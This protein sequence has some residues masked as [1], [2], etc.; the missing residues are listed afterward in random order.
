MSTVWSI[1][2]MREERNQA[3]RLAHRWV[4]LTTI[5]R[6]I[7]PHYIMGDDGLT[8]YLNPA[9]VGVVMVARKLC[10]NWL[11][12]QIF[13]RSV[14]AKDGDDTKAREQQCMAMAYG[15]VASLILRKRGYDGYIQDELP[16]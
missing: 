11:A 3:E 4:G 13:G 7:S 15:L 9:F 14:Y 10:P 5:T 6:E 16:F 2:R 8:I 1:Q 12:R